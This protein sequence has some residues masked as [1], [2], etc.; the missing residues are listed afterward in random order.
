LKLSGFKCYAGQDWLLLGISTLVMVLNIWLLLE[1]LM[2][3]RGFAAN[4]KAGK[5]AKESAEHAD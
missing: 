1:G 5:F 4:F 3:L 2:V